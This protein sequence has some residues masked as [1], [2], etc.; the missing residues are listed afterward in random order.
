MAA[1][2]VGNPIKV[3][4]KSEKHKLIFFQIKEAVLQFVLMPPLLS[5]VSCRFS[6]LLQNT[7]NYFEYELLV[8][9]SQYSF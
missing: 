8:T 2:S 9:Y 1:I 5:S 4:G 7:E 6:E 3:I